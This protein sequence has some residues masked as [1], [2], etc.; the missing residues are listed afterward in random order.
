MGEIHFSDFVIRPVRVEDLD[1][2]DDLVGS[3][4]ESMTSLPKDRDFL[5]RRIMASLRAFDPLVHS[6][7]SDRYLFVLEDVPRQIVA[8]SSG[9]LARVGGFDPFYSY[10]IRYEPIRHL[11]LG[12]DSEIP[13]LHLEKSHKGPSEL[14]SLLL[15]PGYRHSGLGRM[16]SLVR[17]LFMAAFPYR[18]DATVIAE[19][20]GV[21]DEHGH[22]PFWEAVGR[23]FF[24]KDF[25]FADQWSGLGDKQFIEDLMPKYPIY[26]PLLPKD[27][28]AVIGEVHEK[29]KPALRI[30]QQEGFIKTQHVDIFDAGPL[31]S[32]PLRSIRTVSESRKSIIED[33]EENA[34]WPEKPTHILAKPELDF[35]ACL[36]AVRG[37]EGKVV[38]PA[39]ARERLKIEKGDPVL[40]VSITRQGPNQ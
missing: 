37:D 19:L 18:F 15:H 9:I 14:C 27:A 22:S 40:H 33:F 20:R 34:A 3:L 11:P 38:L 7:G 4:Q 10:A 17:F 12:I 35:R 21:L 26:I 28:Q 1:G 16:V 2:L 29:T 8:G 39:Y 23:P 32:A 31:L 5:Y 25:H 36:G 24:Q 13:T 6:A 30:L